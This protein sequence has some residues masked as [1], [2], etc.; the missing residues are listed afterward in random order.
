MKTSGG[1]APLVGSSPTASACTGW[2]LQDL[3]RRTEEDEGNLRLTC[4]LRTPA[5][6]LF[7]GPVVQRLRLLAYIQ[8]TMVRF[9]PGLLGSGTPNGRAARLGHRRAALVAARLPVRLRLG[10]CRT[11]RRSCGCVSWRFWK[12]W[13]ATPSSTSSWAIKVWPIASS[14]CCSSLAGRRTTLRRHLRRCYEQARGPGIILAL[15]HFFLFRGYSVTRCTI[16]A[17]FTLRRFLPATIPGCRVERLAGLT[18]GEFP[19]PARRRW[20]RPRH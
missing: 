17:P 18:R 10:C 2:R 20:P 13:R 5:F 3:D 15:G 9:R 4:G 12:R 6:G 19:R 16:R 14:T 8:E 1:L 7:S 11:T